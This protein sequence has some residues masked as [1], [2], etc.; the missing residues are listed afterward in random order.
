M[1]VFILGKDMRSKKFSKI[2]HTLTIHI[3][4]HKHYIVDCIVIALLILFRLW[5]SRYQILS[6]NGGSLVDDQLFVDRAVSILHGEW[7]GKYNEYTLLKGV[8]YPLW[9]AFVYTLRIPLLTS[10]QLLFVASSIV[11]YVAVRLRYNRILS[12]AVF[13]VVLFNPIFYQVS[14]RIIRYHIYTSFIILLFSGLLIS[15]YV[16]R[17]SY[18]GYLISTLFVG[19][20]GGICYLTKEE[21]I[22]LMPL[23]IFSTI[24]GSIYYKGIH[25]RIIPMYKRILHYL[26]GIALFFTGFGIVLAIISLQNY[27]HYGTPII[28]DIKQTSL[29]L[30]YG[31]L[32]R[33]KQRN[34]MPYITVSNEAINIAASISPHLAL[35]RPAIQGPN[36]QWARNQTSEYVEYNTDEIGA[37]EFIFVLRQ[38]ASELRLYQS[39]QV[40]HNY[41]EHIHKEISKACKTNVIECYPLNLRIFSPL[42][43]GD[44]NRIVKSLQHSLSVLLY[45][46]E[47]DTKIS[48]SIGSV[49]EI[50]YLKTIA[51]ATRVAEHRAVAT[52]LDYVSQREELHTINSRIIAMLL[53]VYKQMTKWII[54]IGV[55]S[56]IY[57]SIRS[58]QTHKITFIFTSLTG[59]LIS[60]VFLILLISYIAAIQTPLSK[61][62][63]MAPISPLL[64]IFSL[65]SLA[66][67]CIAIRR[68]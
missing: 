17:Y 52:W 11:L 45:F 58:I 38:A 1:I 60:V 18:T 31:D 34:P 6:A 15:D 22:W 4:S 51:F 27:R 47:I 46:Y 42:R 65:I 55:M 64:Y 43:P 8:F 23:I 54:V 10:Q 2:V 26:S 9:I 12:L 40:A 14:E 29:I 68:K 16:K 3:S 53:E 61:I 36:T 44:I 33:I 19:I 59:L 13:A 57:L 62:I 28:N 5:I 56:Y 21:F 48:P 24:Y 41:F 25:L 66:E 50:N 39:A 49:D 20:I 63:Y 30:V 32:L 7:L 67:C 37:N 35:L